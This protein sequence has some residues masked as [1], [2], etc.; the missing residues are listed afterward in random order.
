[1]KKKAWKFEFANVFGILLAFGF[2]AGGLF[3]VKYR[4]EAEEMSILQRSGMVEMPVTTESEVGGSGEV[5][6][7]R[8]NLTKE[9]LLQVL[10][11]LH[12]P[13]EVS[14]HEPRS[15]QMSMTEAI[16]YGKRWAEEFFLPFFGAPDYGT[17]LAEGNAG[18]VSLSEPAF[19]LPD[20]YTGFSGL[21]QFRVNCYLWE[22]L[23]N[24]GE[25]REENQ[26]F[27]YWTVAISNQYLDLTLVLNAVTGQ[28]LDADGVCYFPS[29]DKTNKKLMEL[30]WN[31]AESFGIGGNFILVEDKDAMWGTEDIAIYQ[32]MGDRM[33][34]AHAKTSSIVVAKTEGELAEAAEIYNV[35]FYLESLLND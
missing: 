21:E 24:Q 11:N 20:G 31:Y 26:I 1:M 17:G 2:A 14:P 29:Q 25:D 33:L 8:E 4:L 27:S 12:G 15:G 23:G 18:T 13:G 34:F 9:Q 10:E 5:Q 3:F 28:V 16:A 7:E 35:H 22:R 30:L 32:A 19:G 6:A